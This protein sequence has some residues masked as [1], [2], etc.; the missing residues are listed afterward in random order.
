MIKTKM[1][2][3]LKSNQMSDTFTN[4]IFL[5]LSGGFQDAY[6]YLCRGKVFANAQTGNI[7]LMSTHFFEGEFGLILHYLIPVIS[8]IFGICVAEIQHIFFKNYKK[9][10]WRQIV[11]AFEI[12]ILLT[13]GFIPINLNILA[14]ALVSFVAAMQVQ[15]FRK[16]RGNAYA[17]T[18]CIGNMRSGAEALCGYFK[19]RKKILLIKAIEYFSIIFMF[20]VGAGF[21]SLAADRWGI[22]S[23]WFSCAFL[24]ISFIIMFIR[25]EIE[26]EK[27][28]EL[29]K[30]VETNSNKFKQ[31]KLLGLACFFTVSLQRFSYAVL[32]YPQPRRKLIL[33]CMC[34]NQEAHCQVCDSEHRLFALLYHKSY[35]VH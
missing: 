13:V 35:R 18:M 10:H 6:T 32:S 29:E 8:F 24:F 7:V 2:E 25:L 16:L 19:T 30:A 20:A 4:A 33:N 11:L 5:T 14:N 31:A 12:V 34:C 21:G 26:E 15:T 22:R 3:R 28:E 1:A 17:S 9:I 23:I 27:E